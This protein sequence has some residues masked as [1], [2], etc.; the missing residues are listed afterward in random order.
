MLPRRTT[1]GY[2]ICM[3]SGRCA[4][5]LNLIITGIWNKRQWYTK[6]LIEL[7]RSY[8]QYEMWVSLG[9]SVNHCYLALTSDQYADLVVR[10]NN[11]VQG[12]GHYF[13]RDEKPAGEHDR[14]CY[15]PNRGFFNRFGSNVDSKLLNAMAEFGVT[16]EIETLGTKT[17]L[18]DNG[19][20]LCNRRLANCMHVKSWNTVLDLAM[21]GRY[22]R[23]VD[24]GS[25]YLSIYAS[26]KRGATS[27]EYCPSYITVVPF[28]LQDAGYNEEYHTRNYDAYMRRIQTNPNLYLQYKGQTICFRFEAPKN[29]LVTYKNTTDTDLIVMTDA[30][31]YNASNPMNGTKVI[32][33]IEFPLVAGL[34]RIGPYRDWET[35]G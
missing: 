20:H 30:H 27:P 13:A 6:D 35:D 5:Y 4:D 7:S 32:S 16:A 21:T 17:K 18:F 28:R 22:K 29:E 25:K 12:D 2:V 23:I 15:D 8:P 10:L 26:F 24:V 14:V 31:Y 19:G 1:N 9:T 11:H 34:H 3:P 33:G